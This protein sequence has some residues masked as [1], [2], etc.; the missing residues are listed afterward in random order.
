MPQVVE[1][2]GTVRED[3]SSNDPSSDAAREVPAQQECAQAA[4]EEA[5]ETSDVDRQDRV[6][7]D[8]DDG[9]GNG[10]DS[11]GGIGKRQAVGERIEGIGLEEVER[12]REDRMCH[13][14][15][16]PG[17]QQGIAWIAH[18]CGGMDG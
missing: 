13:P 4:Q 7:R 9:R 2:I 10:D 16:H 6:V 15:Q 17:E 5:G 3:D 11:Q 8:P 14:R 18:G 1:P 12:M